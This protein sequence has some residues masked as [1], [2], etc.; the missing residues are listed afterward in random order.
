[1]PFF[2]FFFPANRKFDYFLRFSPVSYFHLTSHLLCIPTPAGNAIYF[3]IYFL[4]YFF[5]FS[6]ITF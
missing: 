3:L 6:L 2:F 4:I 1:M 5:I